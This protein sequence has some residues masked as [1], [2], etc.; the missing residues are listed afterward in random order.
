[1]RECRG[2]E[3][4]GRILGSGADH[5]GAKAVSD[6]LISVAAMGIVLNPEGTQFLAS[7]EYDPSGVPFHR[8]LGGWVHHGEHARNA[9]VRIV[10]EQLG[11]HLSAPS[12]LGVLENMFEWR[13]SLS[14]ELCLVF[15][16]F[17]AEPDM[18]ASLGGREFVDEGRELVAQWRP[19]K[20]GGSDIRLYPEGLQDML[21]NGPI[22]EPRGF[23]LG[24][25]GGTVR[26]RE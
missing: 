6:R 9:L 11:V 15:T 10:W 7:R 17:V 2:T 4:P 26:A 8:P 23:T 25:S 24:N 3:R 16:S 22:V 12:P 19:V 20:P 1:M 5:K 21:G 13:G 14:H 18:G